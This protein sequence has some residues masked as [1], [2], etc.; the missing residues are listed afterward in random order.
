MSVRFLSFTGGVIVFRNKIYM[1]NKKN[2]IRNFLSV[3]LIFYVL[4]ILGEQQIDI[5]SNS[6]RLASINSDIENRI[7]EIESLKEK[8]RLINTKEYKEK[9][10]RERGLLVY[11]NEVVFIDPLEQ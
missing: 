7:V 2:F 3:I 10:V 5:S 9:I 1:F 8:L 11:P 6:E 4:F